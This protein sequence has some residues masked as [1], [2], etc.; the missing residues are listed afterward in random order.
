MQK[1]TNSSA[2]PSCDEVSLLN[3]I[4]ARKEEQLASIESASIYQSKKI[5]RTRM[6]KEGAK[7]YNSKIAQESFRYYIAA[8][9]RKKVH[10]FTSLIIAVLFV[11][12]IS[13]GSWNLYNIY[14]RYFHLDASDN[15]LSAAKDY[16]YA[17]D[18]DAAISRLQYLIGQGWN[19]YEV[20]QAL[21][22]AYYAKEDYNS[23]SEV[24]C[25]FIMNHYGTVN[26][27]YATDAYWSLANDAGALTG[28]TAARVEKL[29]AECDVYANLYYK[30]EQELYYGQN[31]KA[32]YDCETLKNTGANN[33]DF[34][35]LYASALVANGNIEKAYEY[36]TDFVTRDNSYQEKSVSL[37]QRSLL[38]RY[39]AGYVNPEKRTAISDLLYGELESLQLHSGSQYPENNTNF[40][41]N[42]VLS[43]LQYKLIDEMKII[44]PLDKLTVHDETVLLFGR[45][46]YVA[47]AVHFDGETQH[48]YYFFY[49]TGYGYIYQ[50][51]DGTYLN[52]LEH[53][54]RELQLTPYTEFSP[55]HLIGEYTNKTS[56]VMLEI[57]DC[58][59]TDLS[60]YY[61]ISMN[62][63][64]SLSNETILEISEAPFSKP[65]ALFSND[66]LSLTFVW[67]S[68]ML[69]LVNSDYSQTYEKISGV[70]RSN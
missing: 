40:S 58:K 41:T 35:R 17:G 34:A 2:I 21:S 14:E 45:E 6:L 15:T 47:D 61:S 63:K 39:I 24:L 56:N 16:M 59:E 4:A 49:D 20:Y 68:E 30:I 69:I 11:S 57:T 8:I 53:E 48:N 9:N 62:I 27:T 1:N 3:G 70:Y 66:D 31:A 32:L 55:T 28:D 52:L 37:E 38:L 65:F 36:I 33:F 50:F 54:G 7:K 67:G 12:G 51:I 46:C 42:S 19:G 26:C 64:D 23:S 60:P 5:H 44:N 13:I 22:L 29:V 18:Y 10:F 25:D 43:F